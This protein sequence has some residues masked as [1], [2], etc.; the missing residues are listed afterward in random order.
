MITG[1]AQFE[2]VRNLTWDELVELRLQAMTRIAGA[3][4]WKECTQT[5]EDDFFVD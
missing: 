2:G 1:V 4:S 5:P 3:G